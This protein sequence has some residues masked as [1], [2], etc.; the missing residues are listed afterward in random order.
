MSTPRESVSSLGAF[1]EAVGRV[2]D[3]VVEPERL[4]PFE[5]LVARGGRDDGC[6]RALGELDRGHS[7]AAGS[8][9]DQ[10]GLALGEVAGGEQALVRGAERHRNARRA[11]RIEPGGDRPGHGRR[12][13]S[14]G[15][16]RP[17]G[18]Q[19]DHPVAD[20]ASFDAGGDLA[21]GPGAQIADDM[22]HCGRRPA[23]RAS[24]SPPS[25]LI[26]S[27]ST[28]TKPSGHPGSGTSS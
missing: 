13:G 27:A 19:G 21:H 23:A 25:M 15:G 18:V 28:I 12:D 6:A 14:P 5:L 26:A 3:P 7:D 17:G 1:D 9:V 24:R 11:G 4:Q 20:C 10:D 2:V 16:V 8:R 22:R